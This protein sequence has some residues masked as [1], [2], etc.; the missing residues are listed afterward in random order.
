MGRATADSRAS[1]APTVAWRAIRNPMLTDPHHVVKDQ[2]VVSTGHRWHAVFSFEDR[3]GRWRIG[4][5]TSPD[6]AHW[7]RVTT[8]PHDAGVAG[9]ASP[10][11]ERAPDGRFVV[12]YQSFATDRAGAR[13]KLYFRTTHDFVRFSASRRLAPQLFAGPDERLID[14]A[15][16]WSPAGL[17]LGFKRGVDRQQFELARSAS[18][19]LRGPWK[20]VGEPDISVRGDTVENYQFLH[21]GG[22]WQLLATSNNGNQPVRLDLTGDPTS[23]AGWLQWGPSADVGR[24]A[25]GV[26]PR[27]RA[28]RH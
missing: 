28:H 14:P 16:V 4:L 11:V 15:V 26:E 10:D 2:A 22:R 9:E 7:S 12:A 8:M 27:H 1:V 17:L 3:T 19:S 23:V 5:R 25:G 20:L 24:A 21:L 13:P 18:G 6:L